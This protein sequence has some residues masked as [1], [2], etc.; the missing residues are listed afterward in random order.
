[1]PV[2]PWRDW[3]TNNPHLPLRGALSGIFYDGGRGLSLVEPVRK[4]TAVAG[5]AVFLVIAPGVV[6]GLVPW[7]LTGW[8]TGSSCPVP[9]RATRSL[10]CRGERVVCAPAGV[11]SVAAEGAWSKN[12]RTC[13]RGKQPAAVPVTGAGSAS[14]PG[15]GASAWDGP[16]LPCRLLAGEWQTHQGGP[17]AG[18]GD[19]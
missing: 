1:M 10:D 12:R 19:E 18:G 7:W 15:G 3:R 11:F 14:R 5:S 4:T 13:G 2:D 9:V 6:A 16:A 8:H 17:G